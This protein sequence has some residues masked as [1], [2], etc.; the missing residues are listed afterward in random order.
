MERPSSIYLAVK[1]IELRDNPDPRTHG[2]EE[3]YATYQAD[4]I[5]VLAGMT[6]TLEA[7]SI[8]HEIVH[9]I[10]D[11]FG[12]KDVLAPHDDFEEAVTKVTSLGLFMVFRDNPRFM[13]WL[14]ERCDGARAEL[15]ANGG[16]AEWTGI[17][18]GR[19]RTN[20]NDV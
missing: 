6:D 15:S 14:T 20:V 17:N 5:D 1:R 16:A 10:F 4:A 11:E 9:A 19:A 13:A 12:V 8:L 7:S 2:G 3:C 18:P